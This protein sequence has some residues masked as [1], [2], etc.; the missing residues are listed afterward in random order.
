MRSLRK[1]YWLAM[2]LV[3]GLRH[4]PRIKNPDELKEKTARATAELKSNAK[5]MAE[6]VREGWSRKAPRH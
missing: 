3:C 2:P 1:S 6:G 5:A 4:A